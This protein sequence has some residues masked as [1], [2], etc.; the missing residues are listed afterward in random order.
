VTC[1]LKSLLSARGWTQCAFAEKI[2]ITGQHLSLIAT[3]RI[4]PHINTA[5]KISK[6]LDVTVIDVWPEYLALISDRSAR[7]SIVRRKRSP[8]AMSK[9]KVQA[10]IAAQKR[11]TK[12]SIDHDNAFPL[13]DGG[14][15][16]DFRIRPC[17]ARDADIENERWC[18]AKAQQLHNYLVGHLAYGCYAQ[19]RRLLVEEQNK[20]DSCGPRVIEPRG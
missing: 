3:A 11:E 8:E 14:G 12:I 9:R 13:A 6:A 20:L 15:Q 1:N 2:G 5:E 4:F 10:A 19:L 7:M 18:Q 16:A 17:S